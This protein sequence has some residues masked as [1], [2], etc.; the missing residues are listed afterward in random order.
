MNYCQ[1]FI[2]FRLEG[3]RSSK[4]QLQGKWD[5]FEASQRVQVFRQKLEDMVYILN[6]E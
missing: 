6:T 3:T 4:M 1:A 5:L 2:E